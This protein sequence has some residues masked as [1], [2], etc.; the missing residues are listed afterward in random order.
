MKVHVGQLCICMWYYYSLAWNVALNVLAHCHLCT[1]CAW[2]QRPFNKQWWIQV[3]TNG[4]G[5]KKFFLADGHQIYLCLYL[6]HHPKHPLYVTV[7][8]LMSNWSFGVQIYCET[9]P[10]KSFLDPPPKKRGHNMVDPPLLR[11]ATIFSY[12][13]CGGTCMHLIALDSIRSRSYFIHHH[14]Y[15][16]KLTTVSFIWSVTAVIQAITPPPLVNAYTILTLKLVRLALA[17]W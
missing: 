8:K 16:F 5:A 7:V 1:K 9:P 6:S 3:F 2:L 17:S 4:K 12:K 10:Q 13:Q 15:T 14:I 11:K